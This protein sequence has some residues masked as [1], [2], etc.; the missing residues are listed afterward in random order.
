[1]GK[2]RPKSNSLATSSVPPRREAKM[3]D[4]LMSRWIRPAACASRK[5]VADLAQEVDGAAGWQGALLF[6]QLREAQAPQVFHDIVIGSIL[7]PAVVVDLDGV[8]VGKGGSEP[9]LAL[10]ALECVRAGVAPQPD[11]L[12]GAG[13]FQKLVLC[14]IDLAHASGAEPV[15]KAIL[16]ELPGLHDLPSEPRDRVGTERRTRQ[17]GSS[18]IKASKPR[19]LNGV[20]P[21]SSPIW[22][23][24][25]HRAG[26]PE[27]KDQQRGERQDG[28]RSDDQGGAA[29]V[30]GDVD[31]VRE[32][33]D[34]GD[35]HAI[36]EDELR[37]HRIIPQREAEH[38]L[39]LRD[40]EDG[41][42]GADHR[43]FQE[44]ER[45]RRQRLPA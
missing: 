24:Q 38:G 44:F 5:R 34:C 45:A 15:P 42:D 18:R 6:D 39:V 27:I 8:G 1:M 40:R 11:E 36:L 35:E 13:A 23:S 28:E 26:M 43:E 12:H 22:P 16:A 3:L 30:L 25:R 14:Q 32:D 17:P 29:P 4:G 37:P 10:E 20:V 33:Q 9:H 19:S 21:C 7:G 2:T 31:S 41:R